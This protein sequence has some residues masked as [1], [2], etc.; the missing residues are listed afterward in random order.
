MTLSS[1][2]AVLNQGL[3]QQ[4]D[5]PHRIYNHPANLFVAGF[6][7]S[8]QMN[9][10]TLPCTGRQAV[11]G[12]FRMPLPD[13]GMAPPSNV[14]MGIRPEHIRLANEQDAQTI[15]GKV[16]LVENLG[17]HNLVSF[18]VQTSRSEAPVVLRAL[19]PPNNNWQNQI[20]TLALPPDQVHWFD[21]ETGDAIVP[22]ARERTVSR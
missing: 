13:T 11:L 8:P 5:T 21:V 16:F 1:K 10:H 2:V 12:D 6:V 7:G 14:V 15:Q 18:R 9:L 3:V 22:A 20:L 17:M 19:L 4:L